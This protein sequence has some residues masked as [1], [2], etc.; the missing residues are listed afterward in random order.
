MS[1]GPTYTLRKVFTDKYSKES[2]CEQKFTNKP[3]RKSWL[4]KCPLV[5]LYKNI[6]KPIT[7]K[8]YKCL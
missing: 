6:L 8:Y 2:V 1:H 3:T 5:I 7:Q 4:K